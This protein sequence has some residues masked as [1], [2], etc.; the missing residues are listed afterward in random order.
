MLKVFSGESKENYY[1]QLLD[2]LLYSATGIAI[3]AIKA[4]LIRIL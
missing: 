4:A 3:K 1:F 2:Y